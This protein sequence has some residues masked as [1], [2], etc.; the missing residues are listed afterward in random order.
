[1]CEGLRSRMRWAAAAFAC[2]GSSKTVGVLFLL[3]GEHL[4]LIANA[5]GD[6][7]DSRTSKNMVSIMGSPERKLVAANQGR[8]SRVHQGAHL[9][10]SRS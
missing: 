5:D 2:G 3:Q 9:K 6:P 7:A 8:A 10:E 1:M 4:I